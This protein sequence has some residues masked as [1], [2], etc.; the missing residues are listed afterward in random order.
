MHRFE[1][2]TEVEQQVQVLLLVVVTVASSTAWLVWLEMKMVLV[3]TE[4]ANRRLYRCGER[5][6]IL[7]ETRAHPA[8]SNPKIA[9]TENRSHPE[10]T[11]TA[12]TQHTHK[13]LLV[14]GERSSD[15]DSYW[16][17]RTLS[18]LRSIAP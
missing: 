12:Y 11:H 18:G 14:L 15:P 10:S 6:N 7:I 9:Y 13:P 1:V 16:R 5:P 4:E 17:L 8:V 2:T 3:L